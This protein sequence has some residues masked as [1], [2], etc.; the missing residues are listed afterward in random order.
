M[1]AGDMLCD[2]RQGTIGDTIMI[3]TRLGDRDDMGPAMPFPYQP[4][5]GLDFR[6]DRYGRHTITGFLQRHQPSHHRSAQPTR[7]AFLQTI[8]HAPHQK[9][10]AEKRRRCAKQPP[11]FGPQPRQ[12]E[13]RQI[14]QRGTRPV[15]ASCQRVIPI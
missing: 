12:I 10:A 14:R 2:L 13:I 8:G 6:R 3:E 7:L 5:A 15:P 4:A 9:I 1:R 11:P